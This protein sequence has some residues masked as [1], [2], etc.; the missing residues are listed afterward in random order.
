MLPNPA[1]ATQGAGDTWGGW[2]WVLSHLLHQH[3]TLL[4]KRENNKIKEQEAAV[5]TD[6]EVLGSIPGSSSTRPR[7][8]NPGAERRRFWK[9]VAGKRKVFSEI[10]EA[11]IPD[12]SYEVER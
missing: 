9:E 7:S 5:N 1:L 11:L 10:P 2:G 3:F 12:L 8:P 4:P 6:S